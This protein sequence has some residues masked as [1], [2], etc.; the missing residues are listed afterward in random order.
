MENG[1][2]SPLYI[3]NLLLLA[4]MVS[5]TVVHASRIFYYRR[6]Y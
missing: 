2:V 3:A 4:F 6:G 1:A 5:G